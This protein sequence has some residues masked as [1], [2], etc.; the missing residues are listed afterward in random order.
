MKEFFKKHSYDMMK[1]FL[2][3]FAVAI[4]GLVLALATGMAEKSTLQIASSVAAIVFYMF[5]LYAMTFEIGLKDKT[6]VD[7][8]RSK[9]SPLTGLYISLCANSLNFL[10]AILITVGYLSSSQ[11][12]SNVGGGATVVAL[13]VEGM[14]TGLLAVNV[15]GIPLNSLVWP[16][17]AIIIPALVISAVG[18]YFGLKGWHLTKILIPK[19]AEEI[20]RAR[21][22]KK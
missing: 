5:L 10:L 13:L 11:F 18:Y 20:E 9:A 19:N 12:L 21:Q 22:K 3:Q 8:G 15:G 7:Y 2:N 17:F 14:Y 6:S 1:M 16:F 4:F